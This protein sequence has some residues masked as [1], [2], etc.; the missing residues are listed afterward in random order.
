MNPR[1][2]MKKRTLHSR[3]S[4]AGFVLVATFSACQS[5]AKEATFGGDLTGIDH[6]ADYLSVSEFSVNGAW[7]AQAGTGGRTTCC[8]VLPEKW[9]QGLVAHVKWTVSDWKNSGHGGRHEADVPVDPYS[10]PEHV[11]VHFLEDGTVRVVVS[12]YYPRSPDYPGPH[13]PIPQKYPWKVYPPATK[14][15]PTFSPSD[16]QKYHL[17]QQESEQ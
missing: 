17:S 11:W 12:R 8:V 3:F 6:L 9:H 7:G 15:G 10:A 14:K 1:R 13:D 2:T 4:T 5:T 16:L